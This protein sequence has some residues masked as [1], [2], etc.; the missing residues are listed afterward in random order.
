MKTYF[1]SALIVAGLI[2]A[3][4]GAANA[5]LVGR[6]KFTTS[7][8]FMVGKT[9]MPA[10]A[11]TVTPMENDHQLM[12][13]SNGHTSVLLPT[14]KDSPKDPPRK[15]EVIFVKRGDTYELREIWDASS[16]VGAEAIPSHG[17]HAKAR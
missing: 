2:L 7:F 4:A 8:P 3:S 11:Y 12:E 6:M 16:S 15:D 9:T 17:E 1:R 13:I 10:G 14:E 5:Q